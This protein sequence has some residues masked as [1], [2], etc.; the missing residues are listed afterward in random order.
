MQVGN[1]AKRRMAIPCPSFLPS[2]LK[3]KEG[4]G[5]T[6]AAADINRH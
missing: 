2:F 4:R 6:Y 1:C 5:G 3:K